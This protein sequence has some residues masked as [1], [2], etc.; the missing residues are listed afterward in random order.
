MPLRL[1]VCVCVL[2]SIHVLGEIV[3]EAI[4]CPDRETDLHGCIWPIRLLERA[5]SS[6]YTTD[7]ACVQ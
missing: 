5:Y 2:D 3:T 6:G 1:G 7:Y 4:Q